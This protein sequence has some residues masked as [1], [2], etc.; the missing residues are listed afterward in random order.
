[1]PRRSRE[2]LDP[3]GREIQPYRGDWERLEEILKPR[4]IK[5]GTF[6]REMIRRTIRQVEDRAT[7]PDMDL[8]VELD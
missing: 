2:P 7:A 5:P 1:M 3:R 8:E 4:K 6:I